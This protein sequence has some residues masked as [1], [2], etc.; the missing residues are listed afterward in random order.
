MARAMRVGLCMMGMCMMN[1]GMVQMPLM[2]R[3]RRTLVAEGRMAFDAAKVT[4][5]RALPKM[6]RLTAHSLD[7]INRQDSD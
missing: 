6:E 4:T 1:M 5:S 2:D 3:V 7:D